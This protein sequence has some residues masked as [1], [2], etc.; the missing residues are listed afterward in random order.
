MS[1]LS[2]SLA[3]SLSKLHPFAVAIAFSGEEPMSRC[4]KYKA[5][6]TASSM[7]LGMFFCTEFPEFAVQPTSE[8]GGL[9]FCRVASLGKQEAHSLISFLLTVI[10]ACRKGDF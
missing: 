6:S 8:L 10:E 5:V 1:N 4:S 2:V 7:F 9:P 3:I